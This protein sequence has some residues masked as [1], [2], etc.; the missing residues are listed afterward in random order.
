MKREV[1]F[2]PQALENLRWLPVHQQRIVTDGIRRHLLE[3]D[4]RVQTRNKFPLRRGSAWADYELRLGS[5]RVL[6]RTEG[7]TALIAVIG[8]K[9]GNI[10]TVQGEDFEL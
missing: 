3:N 1:V 8:L 10:L 6:Y 7:S 4:P 2:K 5:L 9:R